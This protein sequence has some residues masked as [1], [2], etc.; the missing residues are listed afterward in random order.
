MKNEIK[1][2]VIVGGG[3][4][5]W[6]IAGYLNGALNQKGQNPQIDI[7]LVESPD[8]KTI[9][10]GEATIPS[11]SHVLSVIGRDETE[12]MKAT[13]G[14]FKQ[15]IKYVNWYKNDNSFYHH[16]FSRL[17][18]GPIDRSGSDW[19]TSRRDIPF[20]ETVSAQP[21]ICEMNR[22]PKM[23]G[24]WTLGGRLRYAFHMDAAKFGDYVRDYST[25]RGVENI[26]GHMTNALLDDEGYITAIALKDGRK[27]EGDLFIDCTGFRALL[28]E[29]TLGI[30]FIDYSKWLLTDQALVANIPYETHFPGLIRPYTTA[31]ALSSGW[32]WDIPMQ[33]RRSVGYVHS[34]AF[35]S[36]EQAEKE[37]LAYQG[38]KP[39][40]LETRL[41]RFKVGQRQKAWSKNCIAV[42]LSGG[43][44]EP[45]ESTGLY[46]CNLASAMLAEFFPKDKKD[47]APMARRFNRIVSN[48]YYEILDFINMHYCL[49][50][51]D[52]T[53]FWREIQKPERITESLK[54]KLE[55]WHKKSPSKAD[56]DNADFHTGTYPVLLDDPE[57]DPRPPVDTAGLWNHESYEAILY[58]MN[59]REDDF[60][61]LGDAR[62]PA[63]VYPAII[64]R[65]R[66]VPSK[67]PPHHIWL[68]RALGM[69]PWEGQNI[70]PGWV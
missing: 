48:R 43:F 29:Q 23:F 24:E 70:P 28:I 36:E 20:M 49:S 52:D 41:V 17:V 16:P 68:H 8:V 62:K 33:S 59:F 57:F 22:A 45:L 65:L 14:T 19:L 1:K 50:K 37:V 30:K 26:K 4:A 12:F 66:Q 58:G 34:S 7:T 64:N 39:G 44:I 46:L 56:F 11:I 18:P 40:E 42:G 15:S 10:V 63:K 5:G 27:I 2:V 13:D 3:S 53:P 61:P 35:I 6:T 51:R 54:A 31:T 67:L 25:K 69:P 47:L 32:V 55:L 38:A 21:V 60:A 9:T